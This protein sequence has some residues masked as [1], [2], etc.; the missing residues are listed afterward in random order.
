MTPSIASSALRTQ[1]PALAPESPVAWPK[2]TVRTLP[3][4][5]QVVLVE[6]RNF[7]KISAQLYFRSGNAVVA[8]SA[9]G[10]A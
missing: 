6:S 5:L 7:P 3:N 1:P 8:H 2:R 9:P 4:G 10:L